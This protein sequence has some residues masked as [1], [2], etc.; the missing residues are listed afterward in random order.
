MLQKQ[1]VKLCT[2]DSLQKNLCLDKVLLK[3][4]L[5][6]GLCSGRFI[7]SDATKAGLNSG[8]RF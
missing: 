5:L 8:K 4:D 6:A 3:H 7:C 1:S 2:E